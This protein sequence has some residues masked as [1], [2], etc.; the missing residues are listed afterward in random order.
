MASFVENVNKV[1]SLIPANIEDLNLIV[2]NI[3]AINEVAP[4]AND[5]NDIIDNIVPNLT[6]ILEADNNATIA[7]EQ[8]LL[9]TTNG[10][11]QVSLATTQVGLATTAK[12]IA[13]AKAEEATTKAGEA[14]TSA[15]QALGY[16]N[17]AEGFRD[18]AETIAS[19][20]DPSKLSPLSIPASR[21]L[22]G[23]VAVTNTITTQGMNTTPYIGNGSTQTV[24]TGIDMATQW[25][26]DASEMFGGLVWLKSRSLAGTSNLLADS[27]RGVTNSIYT[28]LTNANTNDSRVTALLSNGFTLSSNVMINTN[29]A[30]YASWNFQTTHRTSGTTNHG[31]AYTCHYNPFTGFTMVK[32]EG[33]GVAGHEIPNVLGRKLNLKH[34]KNLSVVEG[35]ASTSDLFKDRYLRLNET[36]ALTSYTGVYED[37]DTTIFVRGVNIS[38]NQYIL[39]GWANSYYDDE[40][41][42][43]GSYEVGTYVGT[44]VAGNKVTTKGKP[45]WLMIKRLD[46][47]GN[48]LLLDNQRNAVNSR[49]Y[50]NLSIAESTTTDVVDFNA[51]SFTLVSNDA[52]NNASG[53]SYL[54]MV[55]YDTNVNG[56]GTYYPRTQDTSLLQVTDAQLMYSEG[57]ANGTAKNTSEVLSG[58]TYPAITY[59]AG[60]NYVKKAKDGSFSA[61]RYEPKFG[62]VSAT[63]DYYIEGK[64]YSS[65]GTPLGNITYL[66]I[67]V[68]ADAGGQIVSLESWKYPEIVSDGIATRSLK[69]TGEFDL[70]Q[71]WQDM[72]AERALGIT[73]TNTSGKPMPIN[74]DA[75]NTL[76]ANFLYLLVDGALVASQGVEVINSRVGLSS[77]VPPNSTYLFNTSG[78]VVSGLNWKELR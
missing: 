44:G 55:A 47:T 35:W 66:P 63:S 28:D 19:S 22:A 62:E 20:I 43:K 9:A 23:D 21:L 52:D 33:S 26:N 37:T 77:T 48:W 25:G 6:E 10:A 67:K 51:D 12:D 36:T 59:S 1:A 57:Y 4:L 75:I 49:L 34:I 50:A 30:T 16:R 70:G 18:D 69:V 64:W 68:L 15:T 40:G 8:A 39:Y 73:Y 38:T 72:T 14:S 56:G 41:L 61:T 54:Y 27:C 53:G 17:E 5:L 29:L 58:N 32:Y 65:V 60:Y 71:T 76:A 46:S 74:I 31:K 2:Q 13:V 45:A 3:D 24:V 42:L 7:T 78:G 11:V